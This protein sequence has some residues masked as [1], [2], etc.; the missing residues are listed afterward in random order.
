MSKYS[1]S[2]DF[3]DVLDLNFK[4][5]Q[6]FIDCTHGVIYQWDENNQ[7]NMQFIENPIDLVKYYSCKIDKV[8]NN[9]NKYVIYLEKP[10]MIQKLFDN[11]LANKNIFDEEDINYVI[12]QAK[13]LNSGYNTNDPRLIGA[14]MILANTPLESRYII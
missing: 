12:E 7:L 5:F 3:K 11:V 4:N 14:Y 9:C 10:T 8:E 13:D 2:Q 6:E 1:G